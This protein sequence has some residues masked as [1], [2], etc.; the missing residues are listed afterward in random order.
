MSIRPKT[1]DKIVFSALEPG[2][3]DYQPPTP[4]PC[5]HKSV[6]CEECINDTWSL[7][8]SI[9]KEDGLKTAMC[10]LEPII[11]YS[12]MKHKEDQARSLREIYDQIEIKLKAVEGTSHKI[13]VAQGI[14]K[15]NH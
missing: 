7:A 4:E 5:K 8:N 14:L 2:D 6:C 11:A 3:D 15:S 10:V 12:F 1:P 9:G 13:R